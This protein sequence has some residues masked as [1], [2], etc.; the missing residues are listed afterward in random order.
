MTEPYSSVA[1]LLLRFDLAFGNEARRSTSGS[2][3][4]LYKVS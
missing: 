2:D 1:L 3:Y 4:G